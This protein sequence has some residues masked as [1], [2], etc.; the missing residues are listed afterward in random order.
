MFKLKNVFVFY[1]YTI[2]KN[3]MPPT[4]NMQYD[5]NHSVQTFWESRLQK[6]FSF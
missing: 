5:K 6:R 1:N 4:C 3:L 2:I